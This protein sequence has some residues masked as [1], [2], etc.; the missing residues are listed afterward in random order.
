MKKKLIILLVLIVV[1]IPM[2]LLLLGGSVAAAY[3]LGFIKPP[4]LV[5]TSNGWGN[6]TRSHTQIITSIT[7]DNPNAIGI[8]LGNVG[9]E[10]DIFM[11]DVL[12]GRGESRGIDLPE[13]ISTSQLTTSI[14]NSLIPEWWASHI[15]NDEQTE[16][17]VTAEGVVSLLGRRLSV[18]A[19]GINRDFETDLLRNADSNQHETFSIGPYDITLKERRFQWGSVSDDRTE[20]DGTVVVH[21]GTPAPIPVTRI[22]FDAT[23]NGILIAQGSTTGQM[24]LQPGEDTEIPVTIVI[25]HALLLNWWPTHI[26]NDERTDYHIDAEATLVA[27][28]P[29]IGRQILSLPLL[30]HSDVLQTNILGVQ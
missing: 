10:A 16:V 1:G 7:I 12:M 22:E 21:N 13:G 14:D 18:S 30:S 2:L 28:L 4:E 27:D 15:A 17:S 25:E 11:N 3:A 20:I 26:N 29:V 19:P 6:V 8:G 5:R 24:V 23:M 9:V